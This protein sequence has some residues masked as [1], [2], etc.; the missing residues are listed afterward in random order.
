MLLV[1]AKT[2]KVA[3]PLLLFNPAT[4][5]NDA[6]SITLPNGRTRHVQAPPSRTCVEPC[7]T[8][9]RPAKCVDLQAGQSSGDGRDSPS[10]LRVSSLG[11]CRPYA[12]SAALSRPPCPRVEPES[13]ATNCRQC[14]VTWRV[15]SIQ[16]ANMLLC[17]TRHTQWKTSMLKGESNNELQKSKYY[18][19]LRHRR[20]HR[21]RGQCRVRCK[22]YLVY[23]CSGNNDKKLYPCDTTGG[24]KQLAACLKSASYFALTQ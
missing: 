5:S 1:L 20:C 24:T 13:G 10:Q 6:H 8:P 22:L 15:L 19:L 14:W 7:G 21:D 9:E 23:L 11:H 16:D 2:V 17:A 4:F 12:K 3:R 18:C